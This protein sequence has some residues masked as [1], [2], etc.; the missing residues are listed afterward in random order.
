MSHSLCIISAPNYASTYNEPNKFVD[1]GYNNDWEISRQ[2][3]QYQQQLQ[4]QQQHQQQLQQQQNHQYQQQQHQSRVIPIQ[5][6]SGHPYL[7][8][9]PSQ[10]PHVIQR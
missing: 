5:L 4:Q 2:Q 6:E 7:N 1:Q 9:P 10:A 8:G 3:Q